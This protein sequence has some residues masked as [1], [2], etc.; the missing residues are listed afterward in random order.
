M[1]EE[2]EGGQVSRAAANDTNNDDNDN[3]DN[4]NNDKGSVWS[5]IQAVNPM[6][7]PRTLAQH[8]GCQLLVLIIGSQWLVKGFAGGLTTGAADYL[9]KSY[10]VTASRLQIF[11]TVLNLPQNLAPVIGFLSDWAPIRGY[12]KSPYMA[13]ASVLGVTSCAIIGL[14]PQTALSVEGAVVCGFFITTQIFALNLL[15]QATYSERMQSKPAQAPSLVSFAS[16]GITV[17]ALLS[18]ILV[19]LLVE[20]A[21]P[22]VVYLVAV[23]ALAV[24]LV[25]LAMGCAGETRQSAQQCAQKRQ[26]LAQQKEVLFIC[27]IIAGSSLLLASVGLSGGSVALNAAVAI[28]AAGLVLVACAVLLKPILAKAIAFFIIVTACSPSISGASFYFF[29]DTPAQ[30]AE[31]PHFSPIFYSSVQGSVGQCA[32]LVGILIYKRWMSSWTY[33]KV[34]TVS[35]LLYAAL[36]LLDALVFA[37]V[38]RRFGISDQAFVLTS[39]GL[40]NLVLTW[41]DM[42]STII[43]SQLC[44]EGMEA[45]VFALV[46]TSFNIGSTVGANTGALLLQWLGCNPS[47]QENESLQFENLWVAAVV[48]AALQVVPLVL[49]LWLIPDCRQT[50]NLMQGIADRSATDGSLWK[51][52]SKADLYSFDIGQFP[53]TRGNAKLMKDLFPDRFT[54]IEGP[55]QE[56]AKEF[57]EQRPDVKCDVISVDGDHSTEGTLADLENFRKLASCRNWVL[58][59]DAG[60]NSTNSAWQMAKDAGI[61]TQVECFADMN[62]KPDFQFMD[63]PINRSWCLGFFNVGDLDPTCPVWFKENPNTEKTYVRPI[64]I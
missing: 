50:D 16:F 27:V 32:M 37:R 11:K 63:F 38:N 45:I 46:S 21:G 59:D 12:N 56:S 39:S 22:K 44:P 28:A 60:W 9:F 53:Y 29:T 5:C 62:P 14:V 35:S 36:N 26:R 23:P 17:G 57:A 30:Y 13:M 15:T 51:R 24:I 42:P 2:E 34:M 1:E 64:E 61:I 25:L 43:I 58:M 18:T 7:W 55:S 8:F 48:S 4:N 33:R 52:W 3:N 47:G 49:M 54:Y 6:I 31:G 10:H 19:G 41:Q 20:E 40:E